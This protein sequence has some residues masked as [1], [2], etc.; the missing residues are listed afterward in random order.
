MKKGG[1]NL[2]KVSVIT[3]V[4]IIIISLFV[5]SFLFNSDKYKEPDINQTSLELISFELIDNHTAIIR[6][7]IEDV[8]ADF[9]GIK[10]IF[11]DKN[12]Q[13]YEI[14]KNKSL[15]NQESQNYTFNSS[16]LDL[17]NFLDIQKV[18]IKFVVE[19]SEASSPDNQGSGGNL[20]SGGSDDGSSNSGSDDDGGSNG[21]NNPCAANCVNKNCGDDGCGGSCG[22]CNAD[23]ETCSSGI[24][25]RNCKNSDAS[26]CSQE[27]ILCNSEI[28]Y[29]CSL[30][31]S[32][33]CYVRENLTACDGGL[34]CV[35]GS[36]CG[37]GCGYII[38][39]DNS[40]VTLE[41][42]ILNC[43]N[44]GIMID[45]GN[46]TLDCNYHEISLNSSAQ[47]YESAGK[48]DC[49]I[50]FVLGH[51]V[52]PSG[53]V[54]CRG[55]GG[56]YNVKNCIIHDIPSASY[57]GGIG[58][59][60]QH[61]ASDAG[62]I[63]NNYI[64]NCSGKTIM[65]WGEFDIIR[66]NIFQDGGK[67][68]LDESSGSL[69]INNTFNNSY[70]EHYCGPYCDYKEYPTNITQNT[71]IDNGGNDIKFTIAGTGYLNDSVSSNLFYNNAVNKFYNFLN[72]MN[73]N[74]N[75]DNSVGITNKLNDKPVFYLE[76]LKGT[77][78]EP[79]IIEEDLSYFNCNNCHN[80]ILNNL[81]SM[82]SFVCV[83]CT[84]ISLV[85][86]II[87]ERIMYGVYLRNSSNIRMTGEIKNHQHGIYLFNSSNNSFDVVYEN[88]LYGLWE[89]STCE[90][91]YLNGE[92]P[93]SS[94]IK[95]IVD[96]FRRFFY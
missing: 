63:E 59:Y 25:L 94:P 18:D 33:G 51:R 31:N 52:Y 26:G 38:S 1:F 34:S 47:I 65:Q 40:V 7:K 20:V 45:A 68:W 80:L 73:P 76:D 62:I 30:N 69:I 29:N 83:D 64:F 84:N 82:F 43:D 74:E 85:N 75:N 28:P 5:I 4:V 96:W 8:N 3:F 67:L 44:F 70:L 55:E 24:C 50:Q 11:Y 90:N 49:S 17:S 10:F 81:T 72:L 91:N 19:G 60:D 9:G 42:D 27:G 37:I 22:T 54:I 14:I 77:L 35:E 53:V 57:G 87:N 21:G 23:N 56:K 66:N 15:K 32:D 61:P 93:S 92:L 41:N 16:D 48:E 39:E 6:L 88:N 36:G 71:F 13:T 12:G 2:V 95:M 58:N 86:A 78:D 46:V 89:S 79:I